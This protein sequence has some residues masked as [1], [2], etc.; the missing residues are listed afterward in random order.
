ML[1]NKVNNFKANQR[2]ST[3]KISENFKI[4][5]EIFTDTEEENIKELKNYRVST[6]IQLIKEIT[7]EFEDNIS[8]RSDS[9]ET[10]QE[11]SIQL[12][13]KSK[14]FELINESKIKDNT[15]K[16]INENDAN[17][18]KLY[19]EFVK[20]MLNVKFKIPT[21]HNG[22]KIKEK[23]LFKKALRMEVPFNKWTE[24]IIEELD[25]KNKI[26]IN[27]KHR[28]TNIEIFL[29]KMDTIKEED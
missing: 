21:N 19:K 22:Q 26:N 16:V 28:K 5:K 8:L 25:K 17:Y 14:P 1:K 10:S 23:D 18:K 29:R 27:N 7:S 15:D 20:K 11:K 3:N 2:Y 4:P 13:T 24:F 12:S 6:N 9:S